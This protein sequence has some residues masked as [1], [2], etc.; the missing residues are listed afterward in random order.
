MDLWDSGLYVWEALDLVEIDGRG[1]SSGVAG[2]RERLG[3]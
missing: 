2:E 1:R 3:R